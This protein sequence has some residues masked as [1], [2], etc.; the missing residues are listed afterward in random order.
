MSGIEYEVIHVQDPILFVIRKQHRHSATQGMYLHR[1]NHIKPRQQ[2][3]LY[4]CGQVEDSILD[5]LQEEDHNRFKGSRLHILY[6]IFSFAT[7][8]FVGL[9]VPPKT[10]PE[11]SSGRDRTMRR[12]AVK[13]YM[14]LQLL[15]FLIL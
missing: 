9:P 13:G 11:A 6:Y 2:D 12:E 8:D 3:N 4:S 15:C 5:L 7:S 1:Q 14:D 10:I